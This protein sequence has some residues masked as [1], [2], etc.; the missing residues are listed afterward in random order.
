MHLFLIDWNIV[1]QV[2]TQACFLDLFA[3]IHRGGVI[4]IVV[5]CMV[6]RQYSGDLSIEAQRSHTNS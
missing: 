6:S 3:F 5:N 1:C 2:A 4:Y